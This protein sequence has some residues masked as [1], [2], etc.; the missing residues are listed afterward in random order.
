MMTFPNSPEENERQNASPSF[1]AERITQFRIEVPPEFNPSGIF[2]QSRPGCL[3]RQNFPRCS[4]I[5]RRKSILRHTHFLVFRLCHTG[6][7]HRLHQPADIVPQ[8]SHT[9]TAFRNPV[10]GF[11]DG[12]YHITA[13][14]RLHVSRRTES[15]SDTGWKKE[16][17]HLE[18]LRH[19]DHRP[20]ASAYG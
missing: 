3:P 11:P 6:N 20:S 9:V 13:A 8:C 19:R 12:G 5:S 2:R 15:R 18:D 16:K 14:S 4:S 7:L 10:E 1:T 17:E